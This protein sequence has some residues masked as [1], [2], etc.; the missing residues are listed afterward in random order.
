MKRYK[1]REIKLISSIE[2]SGRPET[3]KILDLLLSNPFHYF[4]GIKAMI[5]GIIIILVTGYLAFLSD[6]RFT[7]LIGLLRKRQSFFL[8]YLLDGLVIWSVMSL[9]LLI[10]GKIIS[11]SRF[12][13]ID[14]IGTQA[15]A[16]FPYLIFVLIALIPG[17]ITATFRY[18]YKLSS[19]ENLTDLISFDLISFVIFFGI[20][21]LTSIW[22]IALMYRAFSVSCNVSGKK[23]ILG[24]FICIV[25]GW[26]I[27]FVV[28]RGVSLQLENQV[29]VSAQKIDFKYK[30]DKLI[31]LFDG[32]KFN[33]A[34]AMYSDEMRTV[35][36]E[37]NMKKVWSDTISRFGSYTK[38]G[39]II[40]TRKGNYF[41]Y[42]VICYFEKGWIHYKFIFDKNGKIFRFGVP[43]SQY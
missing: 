5:A 40:H 6:I 35:Y 21:I 2:R 10:V 29:Q 42:D 22:V 41:I 32:N 18:E 28:I 4:A 34:A 15:L 17:L 19:F 3:K 11:K 23:A 7:A 30:V 14:V 38:H 12:R 25:I 43:G 36:S 33:E 1:S 9:L 13:I 27:S 39:Q 26:L 37:E 31:L 20:Y 16:R 8:N 24:F